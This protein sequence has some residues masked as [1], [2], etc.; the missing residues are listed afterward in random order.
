MLKLI[1]SIMFGKKG[2][3]AVKAF[4]SIV[5]EAKEAGLVEQDAT[6]T[7][8]L[9]AVLQNVNS[10]GNSDEAEQEQEEEKTKENKPEAEKPKEISLADILAEVKKTNQAVLSQGKRLE[11]VE[12][13]PANNGT[14]GKREILNANQSGVEMGDRR[15]FPQVNNQFNRK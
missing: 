5:K 14:T 8:V 9:Q 1:K 10:Q 2:F 15:I 6:E 12:N 7:E 3:D 13:R 4:A 11:K